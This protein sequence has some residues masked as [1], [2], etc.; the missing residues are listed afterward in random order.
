MPFHEELKQAGESKNIFLFT[1]KWR[2]GGLP[3]TAALGMARP[4][5]HT[6]TGLGNVGLDQMTREHTNIAIF[7]SGYFI[8]N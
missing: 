5:T 8:I 7:N 4:I 1:E 2:E 6:F 3:A